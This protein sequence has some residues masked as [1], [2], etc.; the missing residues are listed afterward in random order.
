MVLLLANALDAGIPWGFAL[1]K[2]IAL[3]VA[4]C[5]WSLPALYV[6]GWLMYRLQLLSSPAHARW[7]NDERMAEDRK[8]M[9]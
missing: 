5:L 6:T 1:G 4:A 3:A 2:I 8:R 9:A 7:V